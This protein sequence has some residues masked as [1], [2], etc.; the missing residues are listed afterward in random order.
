MPSQLDME[1]LKG[2]KL[3]DVIFGTD[4]REIIRAGLGN[5][6]IYGGH[7]NDRIHGG[8]GN[9]FI[10]GGQGRDRLN[11]GAGADTFV[12]DG[13]FDDDII[14]DFNA[15]DGDT[16]LFI[17]YDD[18]QANWT[19]ADMLAMC[20]QVGKHVILDIPDS[21]EQVTIRKT[22]LSELTADMFHTYFYEEPVLVF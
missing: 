12:F 8:G 10:S 5:D 9:D 6:E 17:V 20:E 14:R 7:G 22:E 1:R 4:A 21:D 16:F 3:D 13:D 15:A 19:G 11:G 2:S 18:A